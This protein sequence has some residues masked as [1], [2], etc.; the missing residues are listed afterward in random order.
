MTKPNI[1]T[2]LQ[3]QQQYRYKRVRAWDREEGVCIAIGEHTNI[4]RTGGYV[5]MCR[6]DEGTEFLCY[7][8]EAVI[9]EKLK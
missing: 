9:V 8:T 5:L 4:E 6:R 3:I 2:L 1:P 7:I